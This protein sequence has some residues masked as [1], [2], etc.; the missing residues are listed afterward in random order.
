MFMFG[1]GSKNPELHSKINLLTD[2]LLRTKMETWNFGESVGF[3]GLMLASEVL[4]RPELEFFL[5]GWLRGW[6]A[7]RNPFRR[8][9]TTIPG[10]TSVK[11]AL[12][13]KDDFIMEALVETSNYLRARKKLFGIYETWDSSPLLR[14]YGGVSLSP[15]HAKLL[16]NPPAGVFIDCLHFDPPFFAAL[17]NAV[18]DRELMSDAAHQALAYIDRLQDPTGF[19]WHFALE[20]QEDNFGPSWGRGQGWALLGLVDVIKEIQES[21]WNKEFATQLELLQTAVRRLVNYMLRHQQEDGHWS[22]RV[23]SDNPTHE[24]ST[25]AFMYVGMLRA[26]NIGI[27]RFE[28]IQESID[29]ALEATMASVEPSGL[30][31]PVSAAVMACTEPR[32]YDHVPTGFMVPWGQGPALMA[33]C[34]AITHE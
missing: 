30:L 1:S 34:E 19:F 25:A 8:L 13:Y 6:A 10:H 5:R 31:N 32:H 20:G 28:E 17:A 14:P 23:E 2:T 15:E 16:A 27:V 9:D 11:V 33:L 12:K 29:S 24:A 4:E 3:E 18:Q 7:R 21:R 26:A 22:A